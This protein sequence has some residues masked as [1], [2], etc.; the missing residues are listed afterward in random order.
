MED[1]ICFEVDD[2]MDM[3]EVD[4]TVDK[5]I[6]IFSSFPSYTDWHVQLLKIKTDKNN[7][8]IYTGRK[9]SLHPSGAV[10]SLLDEISKRYSNSKNGFLRSYIN[11]R[12][13]DGSTINNVIYWLKSNDVL[14]SEDYNNLLKA[15]GNPDSELNP[16][17]FDFQACMF[18]GYRDDCSIKL[19]SIK[20]PF[21]SLKHK[22]FASDGVFKEISDKVLSL[23]T[24]IDVVI[25]SG[26]V[27]FLTLDG[28]KLFNM[29]RAYKKCGEEKVKD[30]I[31]NGL[32]SDDK[33]FSS[34]AMKGFNPRRLVSLN[35]NHL[36]K[37][38]NINNRKNIAKKFNIPMVNDK[39]D[40]G[41][42]DTTDKLI[43][44]LCDRGMVDPFD[45]DAME[46]AGS[47]KWK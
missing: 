16:L 20:S 15:I 23:S 46:V 3:D 34:E 19:I 35:K 42:S 21:V 8:T 30:I 25:I 4:M 22:F 33:L 40:V 39:F 2:K 17:D 44:V 6:D 38:T 1:R 11:V 14:I 45:N 26:V 36:N 12:K 10:K 9:I 29:D 47:K 5:M 37:L 28:E 32:V 31:K 24:T 41:K 13:Y 7:K 27:Y 43:K 18:E